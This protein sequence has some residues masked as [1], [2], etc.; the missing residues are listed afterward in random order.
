MADGNYTLR[1]TG[2]SEPSLEG[3]IFANETKLYFHSK[4]VSVF[5]FT[6]KPWYSQGQTG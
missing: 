6:A 5:I 2:Y 4:Q 3:L 1:V